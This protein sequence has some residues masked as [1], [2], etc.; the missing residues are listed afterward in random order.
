MNSS[1][2]C[3]YSLLSLERNLKHCKLGEGQ[4][5]ERLGLVLRNLVETVCN[6]LEK[7]KLDKDSILCF[8]RRQSL[9][10][11]LLDNDSTETILYCKYLAHAVG[12]LFSC[13]QGYLKSCYSTKLYSKQSETECYSLFELVSSELENLIEYLQRNYPVT[14]RDGLYHVFC[15]KMIRVV[16]LFV[17]SNL[18]QNTRRPSQVYHSFW[19]YLDAEIESCSKVGPLPSILMDDVISDNAENGN[20]AVSFS[21]HCILQGCFENVGKFLSLQRDKEVINDRVQTTALLVLRIATKTTSIC[22]SSQAIW[23]LRTCNHAFIDSLDTQKSSSASEWI[24]SDDQSGPNETFRTQLRALV[25]FQQLARHLGYELVPIWNIIFRFETK[26]LES[27]SITGLFVASPFPRIRLVSAKCISEIIACGKNYLSKMIVAPW[28]STDRVALPREVQR[29]LLHIHRVL[30]FALSK[31][32][33]SSVVPAIVRC[34]SIL[35][36]VFPYHLLLTTRHPELQN[37]HKEIFILFN[38]LVTILLE[39]LKREKVDD[40]TYSAVVS[41]LGTVLSIPFPYPIYQQKNLEMESH[42]LLTLI[43]GDEGI[44]STLVDMRNK[45]VCSGSLL[46]DTYSA[47]CQVSGCYF[48]TIFEMLQQRPEWKQ[49]M[50][51]SLLY[52]LKNEALQ[53]LIIRFIHSFMKALFQVGDNQETIFGHCTKDTWQQ[54]T[55]FWS[56]IAKQVLVADI[57]HLHSNAASLLLSV[58]AM[59]PQNLGEQPSSSCLPLLQQLFHFVDKYRARGNHASVRGEAT[60][61]F[62]RA[63][64]VAIRYSYVP[65]ELSHVVE[66]IVDSLSEQNIECIFFSKATEALIE[67]SRLLQD[68]QQQCSL[69]DGVRMYLFQ[70]GEELAYRSLDKFHS[71]KVMFRISIIR[72]LGSIVSFHDGNDHCFLIEHPCVVDRLI[73]LLCS[74]LDCQTLPSCRS[75]NETKLLWNACYMLSW[76]ALHCSHDRKECHRRTETIFRYSFHRLEEEYLHNGST[77]V[78]LACLH[79]LCSLSTDN[80]YVPIDSRHKEFIKQLRNKSSN[81]LEEHWERKWSL[82]LEQLQKLER[83]WEENQLL[84]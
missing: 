84:H 68:V 32:Q 82:A 74:I 33:H 1:D 67:L 34:V 19:S 13:L 61:A 64:K 24:D 81:G 7:M 53:F 49:E 75:L 30:C 48:S 47:L 78:E 66:L 22:G 27:E 8:N 23:D 69:L 11:C 39:I 52:P 3:S 63:T 59:I 2:Y 58:L 72:L 41:C 18:L 51:Q 73:D 4:L 83:L 46:A 17:L 54:L 71:S 40:T 26:E 25:L 43:V 28:K 60:L 20:E 70:R 44:L 38:R 36:K 14:Y 80:N 6:Q 15:V 77:K 50:V 65:L 45:N 35:F 10:N 62:I 21:W 29:I 76:V 79:V 9:L 56:F 31:E 37:L 42:Y 12:N 16:N 55:D 5:K 57:S